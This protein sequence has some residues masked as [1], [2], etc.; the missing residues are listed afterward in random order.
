MNGKM[1]FLILFSCFVLGLTLF[2]PF[3]PV[4]GEE[5]IYSS[6]IRLHVL[7]SS[8]SEEDQALKY[9]V[10]D[11]LLEKAG[12]LF[13]EYKTKKEAEKAFRSRL[14]EIKELCENI[15][16]EN[17]YEYPVSV[18]LREEYYPTREYGGL[19]YPAGNYTSL[20]V[21]IGKAEGKNW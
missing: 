21:G 12:E 4:N 1:R 16:K 15:V 10:R 9:K 2:S 17:G 3:L 6:T 8:D 19:R 7:A 13:E 20:I 5:E 11:G 18:D 14:P